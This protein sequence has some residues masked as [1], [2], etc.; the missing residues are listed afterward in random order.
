MSAVS[1]IAKEGAEVATKAGPK[2]LEWLSGLLAKTP[3]SVKYGL[4]AA[5][6]GLSVYGGQKAVRTM[7]DDIFGSDMLGE[8][9]TISKL[10]GLDTERAGHALSSMGYDTAREEQLASLLGGRKPNIPGLDTG[11][12]DNDALLLD[13][14]VK[15][16][17]AQLQQQALRMDDSPS[18][19]ELM[20]KLGLH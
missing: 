1:T 16:Q 7:G 20:L 15:D 9:S 17:G 18:L 19:A 10:A 2:V 11:M 12:A 13:R 5:G 4:G 14:I 6:A 3:K 8:R